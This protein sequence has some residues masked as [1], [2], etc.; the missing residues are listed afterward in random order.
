[1]QNEQADALMRQLQAP[2]TVALR[3]GIAPAHGLERAIASWLGR[4][5]STGQMN[6]PLTGGRCTVTGGSS[7]ARVALRCTMVTADVNY[8]FYGVVQPSRRLVTFC[9]RVT[10]PVYGMDNFALSRRCLG[11]RSG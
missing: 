1:Q 11:L 2:H 3:P 7:A 4:Q 6:G 8:P 9:Q 5:I 10:P